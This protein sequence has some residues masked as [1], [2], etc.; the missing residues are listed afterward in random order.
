MLQSIVPLLRK[1]MDGE[2]VTLTR[3]DLRQ[4]QGF[5][6]TLQDAGS[7]ALRSDLNSVRVELTKGKITK[8]VGLD[9]ERR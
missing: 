3:H 4:V 2:D 8:L 6:L 9:L 7:E 1:Q 5:I